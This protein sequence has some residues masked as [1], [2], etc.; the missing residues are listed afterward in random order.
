MIITLVSS[1]VYGILN[2]SNGG[3]KFYSP[4]GYVSP[5]VI[6]YEGLAFGATLALIFNLEVV[7]LAFCEYKDSLENFFWITYLKCTD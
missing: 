5:V 4:A 1:A 7:G 6:S 3:Y 2:L